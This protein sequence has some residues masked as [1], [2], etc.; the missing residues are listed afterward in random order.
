MG[1]GQHLSQTVAH[2]N[3]FTSSYNE[4]TH[5]ASKT[6]FAS[7]VALHPHCARLRERRTYEQSLEQNRVSLPPIFLVA[8]IC[9]AGAGSWIAADS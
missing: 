9:G 5:F 4:G 7:W 8:L 1:R 6:S 2:R 3:L